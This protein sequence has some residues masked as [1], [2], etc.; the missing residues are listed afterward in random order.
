MTL[1]RF[2]ICALFQNWIWILLRWCVSHATST[3]KG[4]ALSRPQVALPI[5]NEA[6]EG[7]N[8][9]HAQI[10]HD[11][12]LEKWTRTRFI[13]LL[14]WNVVVFWL[15]L[16]HLMQSWHSYPFKTWLAIWQVSLFNKTQWLEDIRNVVE[17]PHLGLEFLRF[18][19]SNEFLGCFFQT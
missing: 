11:V 2:L 18:H 19:L 17:S 12:L 5:V 6:L 10:F 14:S 9:A 16:E 13:C 15:R 7:T 8:L 4:Q 3:R 1:G